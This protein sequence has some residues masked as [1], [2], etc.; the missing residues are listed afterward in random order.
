M[1]GHDLTKK[2]TM[3]NTKTK[4]MTKTN[5]FREHLQRAI[6]ETCEEGDGNGDAIGGRRFWTFS[7]VGYQGGDCYQEKS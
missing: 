4:T 5:T 1:R 7:M 2:K 3:T 6:P